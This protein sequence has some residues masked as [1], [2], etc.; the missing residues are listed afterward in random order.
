MKVPQAK[1][2]LSRQSLQVRVVH[3]NDGHWGGW[4]RGNS[5]S[6]SWPTESESTIQQ[7]FKGICMHLKVWEALLYRGSV[8]SWLTASDS[9]QFSVGSKSCTYLSLLSHLFSLA[10]MPVSQT[11]PARDRCSHGAL[12][13]AWFPATKHLVQAALVPFS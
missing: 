3:Q 13:T 5:A 6:P 8:N 1:V 11:R 4:N 7:D 9:G 10:L 12:R 2:I